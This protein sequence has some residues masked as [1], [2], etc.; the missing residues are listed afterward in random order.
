VQAWDRG[1]RVVQRADQ[2]VVEVDMAARDGVG[3]ADSCHTW[4]CGG[5]DEESGEGDQAGEQE[6]GPNDRERLRATLVEP[7]Q[8]RRGDGEVKREVGD[9]KERDE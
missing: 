5:E 2:A 8:D 3:E 9:S 7:E 4:R 1:I 6:G